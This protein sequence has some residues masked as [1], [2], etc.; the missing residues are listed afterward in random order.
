VRARVTALFFSKKRERERANGVE[1]AT[2][3]FCVCVKFS[4]SVVVPQ[5]KCKNLPNF[6]AKKTHNNTNNKKKDK[7]KFVSLSA[8]FFLVA[9][10]PK[11]EAP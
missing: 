6:F 10:A 1:R 3:F 5:K 9:L 2:L 7:K 8:V 4:L 11:R